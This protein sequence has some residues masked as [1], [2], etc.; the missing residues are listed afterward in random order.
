MR[1]LALVI[2]LALGALA[3]PGASA[4]AVDQNV[5]ANPDITWNPGTVTVDVGDTVHW[6]NNGGLHNVVLD[7]GSFTGPLAPS[8]ENWDTQFKFTTP[9]RFGYHCGNHGQSMTGVVV[10][11]APGGGGGGGGDSTPPA[12]SSLKAKPSKLC[13]K[14][15]KKCK[16]PGTR[17]SFTLSEAAKVQA[18]VT[19]TKGGKGAV[20]VLQ[21]QF[22]AG[23]DKFKFSGKANGK[24]LSAG[25]YSLRLMATD[26]A[27]NVSQAPNIKITIKKK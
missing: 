25:R 22:P 14:K 19:P 12:I 16:K 6:H 1:R 8:S 11:K 20:I 18:D 7:N 26:A 23:A 5:T 15:S 4:L 27:G 9:G 10:V 24:R 17:V 2:G 13:N 21:K 3:G